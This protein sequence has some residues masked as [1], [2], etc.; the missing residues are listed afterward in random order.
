MKGRLQQRKRKRRR[1]SIRMPNDILMWLESEATRRNISCA[2][3]VSEC[4]SDFR[5]FREEVLLSED[6]EGQGVTA[7]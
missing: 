6:K 3:L 4:V 7:Y 5:A 2:M 1:V